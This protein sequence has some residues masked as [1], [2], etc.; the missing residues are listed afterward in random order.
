MDKKRLIAGGFCFFVSIAF[1]YLAMETHFDIFLASIVR[2]FFS[3]DLWFLIAPMFA[4]SS[5]VLFVR[6]QASEYHR[7]L[8]LSVAIIAGL[9]LWILSAS[10]FVAVLVMFSP[11]CVYFFQWVMSAR[12]EPV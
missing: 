5:G 3:E 1:T 8:A 6:A 4:T 12:K 2:D 7:R 11:L 10:I 9:L